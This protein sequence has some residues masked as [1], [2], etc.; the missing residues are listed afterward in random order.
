MGFTGTRYALNLEA[1]ALGVFLKEWFN[2]LKGLDTSFGLSYIPN[3]SIF[4]FVIFF[5]FN[6]HC[7]GRAWLTL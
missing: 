1:G 5:E 7:A 3:S 4:Y 6:L 2:A